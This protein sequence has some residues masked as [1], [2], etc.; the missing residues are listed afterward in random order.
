[1]TRFV[2]RLA[3]VVSLG[4][5]GVAV[6]TGAK[7]SDRSLTDTRIEELT[8]R[9]NEVERRLAA[10]ERGTAS[11]AALGTTVKAPFTVTDEDGARILEVSAGPRVRVYGDSSQI[12][13][14][15]GAI[16]GGGFFRALNKNQF[17]ASMGVPGLPQFRLESPVGALGAFGLG[18]D[19]NTALV[20]RNTLTGNA[21]VALSQGARGD[22]ILQL[23]TAAGVVMV[24]AGTLPEGIGVVRAGPKF[25]CTGN[26]GLIAS[27]CIQGHP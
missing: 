1:V 23:M 27:D 7:S 22:G 16:D 13:A 8:I 11:S 20:L 9:L 15:I 2:E 24:E 3:L 4:M 18:S 25:K 19:G 21:T 5:L 12:V 10:V 26:A 14:V 6:L 17:E